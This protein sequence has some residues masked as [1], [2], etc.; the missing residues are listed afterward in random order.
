MS[1]ILTAVIM[2]GFWLLLSG[3]FTF[4]LLTSGIVASL[5]VAYFSHELLFGDIDLKITVNRIVRLI[6]YMPWLVWEIIAANI[7][8][9]YRTLHP[10]MPIDPE[11]IEFDTN[12]KTETGIAILANSITLTPGTVTVEAKRD[13]KFKVHSIVRGVNMSG[14]QAKVEMIE[15]NRDV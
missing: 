14:M 4:I 5:I 12:L 15:G 3:H 9:V 11:M 8:I 2:F 6:K 7:D 13:G 1:F 10:S